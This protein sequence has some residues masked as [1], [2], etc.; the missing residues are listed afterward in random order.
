M[1]D[2]PKAEPPRKEADLARSDPGSRDWR[3]DTHRLRSPGR[4]TSSAP[5][6]T[7][8][9]RIKAHRLAHGIALSD[10]VAQVKAL[11]ELDGQA[12]CPSWARRCCPR[13]RAVTNVPARP[14]FTIF[15]GS[16]GSSPP[17]S[18]YRGRASADGPTYPRW[19]RS[20]RPPHVSPTRAQARYR[21]DRLT[22]SKRRPVS[23]TAHL[24][25]PVPRR[26]LPMAAAERRRRLCFGEPFCNFWPGRAWR[27][28]ARSWGGGRHP[29]KMD[30]TLVNA[31][32]SP[33]M[34]DQWEETA[35]GYGKQ[36]TS[37]PPLRLICDVLLDFSEVR[38]MCEQAAADRTAGTP[39]PARRPALRASSG[40]IMIDLGDHRLSRSFF[41]TAAPPPTR[42]ATAAL[43]PG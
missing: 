13:T 43:G 18:G 16:T 20:A 30:D 38:R 24:R 8:P 15:A 4:S 29:R 10:V 1:T 5:R 17:T 34:L 33:T 19:G 14:I 3:S 6:S 12:H 25:S 2:P 35:H 22:I 42:P 21:C 27:S 36:Y 7:A 37:T 32:V 28:M 11:Y 9:A 26:G 23:I 40:V 31:S 39:V 41:R